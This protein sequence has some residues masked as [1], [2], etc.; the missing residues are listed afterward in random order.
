MDIPETHNVH[1]LPVPNLEAMR[2]HLEHL[3]GGYLDGFHDGLIELAWTDT[4][5]D[6]GGRYALRWGTQYGTDQIEDLV[7]NAARLNS[8]R[9]CNVY[10]G[11]ALRKPGTFPG[12]RAS[13]SDFYALPALYIDLD[14]D[15]DIAKA[16]PLYENAKPTKIVVTGV[17]PYKRGQCWWL[18]DEPITDPDA[19]RAELLGMA[20]ALGGDTTVAHPSR[21]M[22]LAG[23]IAWP[24]KPGRTAIELTHI[25]ALKEPGQPSYPAGQ[26]SRLFPPA[27]ISTG[28]QTPTMV[29]SMRIA[30]ALGLPGKVD[31]G[32]DAYI[33]RTVE[34]VLI[35]LIGETGKCP[36]PQRLFDVVWPQYAEHANIV[37]SEGRLKGEKYVADKCA[38]TIQRF[39][40]GRIRGCRSIDEAMAIWRKK[41]VGKGYGQNHPQT[42]KGFIHTPA[43]GSPPY[44]TLTIDDIMDRPDPVWAID[45][46]ISERTLGFIFGPPSSLKT[47]IAIDIA[48]SIVTGAAAWW[49]RPI[50]ATGAVVYL[51]REGTRSLKFRIKAWELHRKAAARGMPFRLVEHPTNFMLQAD[52]DR[53]IATIR[54]VAEETGMP[55]A[56]L[57]VDTVSRVLPGAEENLQRDMTLFTGACEQIQMAFNCLVIGVHHTNKNGGIRGSTVIPGAGDFLL[58]TKR[59]TGQMVG[60]LLVEKVKDGTDGYEIPFKATKIEG[61]GGIVPQSSLVVDGLEA[62]AAAEAAEQYEGGTTDG[63]RRRDILQALHEA[64][65]AKKPWGA[66]EAIEIIMVRWRLK[67]TDAAQLLL[68]WRGFQVIEYAVYD[69]H[70]KAKGYRKCKEI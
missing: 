30:T 29:D 64:W 58:N 16:R 10:I 38:Y 26:L 12:T 13:D 19:V 33:L 37:N 60:S 53:V 42:G 48:L 23:S 52:V 40:A 41:S 9:F 5:P 1:N 50:K 14:K 51:C 31:D 39:T 55:I 66:K 11:A 59:E 4:T 6:A 27:V 8:N 17:Q 35:Q 7:Q 2:E 20:Q 18:L 24:I 34:A 32:R 68:D 36:T 65:E 47:F 44:P 28:I 63:V 25:A 21:V 54:S 61:L 56:A 15:G 69:T 43:T 22:R 62:G 3:F 49:G 45:G 67:K 57:F 46:L 70:T